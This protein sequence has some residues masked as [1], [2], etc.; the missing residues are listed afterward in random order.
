MTVDINKESFDHLVR[1]K[2]IELNIEHASSENSEI[3]TVLD[4]AV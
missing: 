4:E 3:K 1:Q 2:A